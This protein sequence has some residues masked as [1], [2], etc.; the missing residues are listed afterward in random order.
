MSEIQS[1]GVQTISDDEQGESISQVKEIADSK[2]KLTGAAAH[3]VLKRAEG[4][5][6]RLSQQQLAEISLY[7]DK[8]KT[9]SREDV[10]LWAVDKFSLENSPHESLISKLRKP[11]NVAKYQELLSRETIQAKLESKS[12]RGALYEDVDKEMIKWITRLESCQAVLTDRLIQEKAAEVA[13]KLDLAKFKASDGWLEGFKKRHNIR[14]FKL[15]GEAGSADK[16]YVEV[17]RAELPAIL[18]GTDSEDIYN[19]DETALLYRKFPSHTL[20]RKFPSHTFP[21]HTSHTNFHHI[22]TREYAHLWI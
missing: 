11:E 8:H 22:Q 2:R 9:M 14:Q 5:R 20:Y 13:V 15:H 7:A 10:I 12:T 18:Q 16:Q 17:S 19:C 4:K 6:V 3:R 21:S 1:E